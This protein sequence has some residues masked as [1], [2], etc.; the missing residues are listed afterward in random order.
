MF[1]YMPANIEIIYPEGIMLTNTGWNDILNELSR[2]L[3]GYDE[4]ARIA[5]VEKDIIE[6]RLREVL[7]GKLKIAKNPNKAEKKK[8]VKKPAKKKAKK[9]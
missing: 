3:H 9:K 8:P 1:K 7:E 2:R 6:K 5:Q 4:I